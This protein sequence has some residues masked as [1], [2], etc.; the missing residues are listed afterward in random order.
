MNIPSSLP[1][2]RAL[3]ADRPASDRAENL[4]L[5]EWLV[6]QWGMD[7]AMRGAG[8]AQKTMRGMISA[9]WVL[10]G[11]AIQDVFAVPGLFYG[12]SLRFYDAAVTTV[13]LRPLRPAATGSDTAA[14]LAPIWTAL[15]AA[16]HW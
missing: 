15:A 12:T 7:V 9:A 3:L 5:Y 1:L 6:G 10:E 4:K 8:N 11:R 13:A 14:S 16:F 2:V